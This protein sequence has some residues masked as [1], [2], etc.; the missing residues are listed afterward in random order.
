[1]ACSDRM[2]QRKPLSHEL[3]TTKANS[4]RRESK[5]ANKKSSP[6]VYNNTTV[7]IGLILASIITLCALPVLSRR[8]FA[9]LTSSVF[10]RSM[11]SSTTVSNPMVAQP[12]KLL[13]KTRLSP[14]SYLLQYQ[15]LGRNI[16]G[17]DPEIPTCVKVDY[18]DGTDAK[19][20]APK[21]LSK[22]YSPVSHPN[23]HG[24]F[25]LIVKSYPLE[26]GGG[27]GKF[28]CD[29]SIGE[30]IT[31]TLKKERVM[32][33]STAVEGR[34]KNVGLIAGGTGIAP[35]LQIARIL[36]DS[37]LDKNTKIHLLF[38]NRHKEDI[39]GRSVIDQMAKDHP[40]HFFVTYSLTEDETSEF[41]SGR[42]TVEMVKKALPP[43]TSEDAMVF[44]CG[45]DGFVAHW[46]G[47]VV[48]GPK[49][50][51]GSKGPKIQGPL[52]GVLKDA[53]YTAEQVFK[54]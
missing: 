13:H 16:L 17:N 5:K 36:L 45:K 26:P 37:P 3:L 33:G 25:D 21:V 30:S 28:I 31:G 46:G 23:V 34:W 54:Y 44:V 10:G 51:D 42:G 6:S 43:P 7:P 19:T 15:I 12:Y 53:G 27:V 39:L 35:L 1:M 50:A 2:H 8:A 11:T 48:R 18:P 38:I 22:S 47:P 20:G 40:D 32:H 14:D 4:E 41:E 52:E 24:K 49:N 29:M 9:G